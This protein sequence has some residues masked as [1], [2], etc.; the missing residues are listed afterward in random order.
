M[1]ALHTLELDI[2]ITD[3]RVGCHACGSTITLPVEVA[4]WWLDAHRM[5]AVLTVHLTVNGRPQTWHR[6]G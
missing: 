3:V 4:G 1:T 6:C 2:K 5:P